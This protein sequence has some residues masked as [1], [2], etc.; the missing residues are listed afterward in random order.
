MRQSNLPKATQPGSKLQ[1]CPTPELKLSPSVTQH[2]GVQ[3]E[4]GPEEPLHPQSSFSDVETMGTSAREV[5]C[6][7][8]AH[9]GQVVG[10]RGEEAAPS[11]PPAL[12]VRV[13][14]TSEGAGHNTRP[15]KRNYGAGEDSRESLGLQGDP[16]SPS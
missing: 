15:G 5:K 8:Q 12:R 3:Q 4:R 2:T 14:C 1:V 7:G 11:A 13:G 16:T 10:D 9:T 6:Q